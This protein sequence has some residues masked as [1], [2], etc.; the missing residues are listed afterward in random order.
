MCILVC[1]LVKE[2]A[3]SCL[4]SWNVNTTGVK[5]YRSRSINNVINKSRDMEM[6][7]KTH[8]TETNMS[9]ISSSHHDSGNLRDDSSSNWNIENS[10]FS[11]F[12][13]RRLACLS[14]SWCAR[15]SDP[16][17]ELILSLMKTLTKNHHERHHHEG[18]TGKVLPAS[19]HRLLWYISCWTS[20]PTSSSETIIGN[21]RADSCREYISG[22]DDDDDHRNDSS[23]RA[24]LIDDS[25][26]HRQWDY[27]VSVEMKNRKAWKWKDN[28]KQ[29]RNKTVSSSFFFENRQ[30]SLLNLLS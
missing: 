26:Q 10:T 8:D 11:F 14:S 17:L 27:T 18:V 2:T 25:C 4:L 29:I 19:H 15:E 13:G 20:P 1:I 24:S 28:N 23:S 3:V 30:L 12:E 5:Q 21:D 9:K 6:I 16:S 7:K 22:D